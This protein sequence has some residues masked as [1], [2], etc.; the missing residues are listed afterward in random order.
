MPILNTLYQQHN[1]ASIMLMDISYLDAIVLG[2][3]QGATEFIPVSSSGHLVIFNHLLGLQGE[4]VFDVLL[5]FG[6]L[7]ALIIFYRKRIIDLLKRSILGKEWA[8][9]AKLLAATVPAFIIGTLFATQIKLLND[10]IWVVV[11][12]L[13][14]LAIPMIL[15]GKERPGADD[16]P[17]EKSITWPISIK[18]GLMQAVA[19]IPGT[20]RSGITILTG[21]QSKLSAE[22]AAEFSFMLAIP[23]IAGASFKVLLMDGGVEFFKANPGIVI[24]GNLVSFISGFIAVG[25]LLKLLSSRGLKDFGWYRIGLAGVLT[26]LLITGII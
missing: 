5:N 26:V 11:I 7:G 24:V 19:L 8:L 13:V 9:L 16:R 1:C 3:V 14:V 4:F 2:F 17:M 22:R 6:T 25:F 12:M 10:F 15:Y 23:T 20:S 18:V 21:L